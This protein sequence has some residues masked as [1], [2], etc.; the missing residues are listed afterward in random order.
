MKFDPNIHTVDF[1]LQN[2]DVILELIHNC[3]DFGLSQVSSDKR[4]LSHVIDAVDAYEL[5]FEFNSASEWLTVAHLMAEHQKSWVNN[6]V[7]EDMEILSLKDENDYTVAHELATSRPLWFKKRAAKDLDVLSW[8]D[9]LK[10][11]S[12]AFLLAENNSQWVDSLTIDDMDIMLL[13]INRQNQNAEGSTIAGHLASKSPS[14]LPKCF[15][16]NID[17]LCIKDTHFIN[18]SYVLVGH[19]LACKSKDF[20]EHPISKNKD[21]LSLRNSKKETIAHEI[22]SSK[23][24]SN[25]SNSW[26]K[27]GFPMTDDILLLSDEN[28]TTVIHNLLRN[29]SIS[30]EAAQRFWSDDILKLA[31][32]SEF[33]RNRTVAHLLANNYPR[34]VMESSEAFLPDFLFLTYET[35]NERSEFVHK[36]SVAESLEGISLS[37]KIMRCIQAG[38]AFLISGANS[39]SIIYMLDNDLE[40]ELDESFNRGMEYINKQINP[41]IK[42]I[43]TLSLF[44]TFEELKKSV[45]DT[46]PKKSV[47]LNFKNSISACNSYFE[48]LKDL[49]LNSLTQYMRYFENI[50]T[51]SP[52]LN[53]RTREF[54]MHE[55]A[56]LNLKELDGVISSA[57]SDLNSIEPPK[58]Y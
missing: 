22:A 20:I 2:D 54:L 51:K 45:F 15:L 43:A 48:R 28:N 50:E 36:I 32:T 44:T 31:E 41:E 53:E 5:G 11:E 49:V 24:L 52:S 58:F 57:D 27:Y 7:I 29:R 8:T 4:L 21:V 14:T 37:D 56:R 46:K 42:V 47:Q 34:W 33:V 19:I 30:E 38:G 39:K 55:I 3:E 12:V 1:L 26:D 40:S 35:K 18:I 9:S 17:F 13:P 16:E 10:D 6:P 23:L 25:Q